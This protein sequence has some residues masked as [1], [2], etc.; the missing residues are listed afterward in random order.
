MDAYLQGKDYRRPHMGVPLAPS[1]VRLDYYAPAPR[2]EEKE[3]EVEEAI[4]GFKEIKA[5]LTT[6]QALAEASRCMSCGLCNLCDQCR[7]F[8]PQEAVSRDMKRPK[9][10]VMFTDYTRCT[11]CHVCYESCPTGYIQMGMGM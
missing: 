8:C 4:A 7:V 5:A 3:I 6:E 9:G 2:N 10:Q 1:E 11:G